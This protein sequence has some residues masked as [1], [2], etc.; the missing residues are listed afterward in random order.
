MLSPYVDYTIGSPQYDWL[1]NDLKAINRDQTPFVR[2]R[3]AL[4][5]WVCAVVAQSMLE[6]PLAAHVLLAGPAARR[7]SACTCMLASVS[8]KRLPCPR[9]HRFGPLGGP[10]L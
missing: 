9:M 10:G 8:G 7:R 4:V 1:L 5:A 2:P 6:A 3:L